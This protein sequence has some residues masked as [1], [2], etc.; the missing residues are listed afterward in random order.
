M[1]KVSKVN[2]AITG[3]ARGLAA[4]TDQASMHLRKLERSAEQSRKRL[5]AM[6]GTSMQT[7]EGLAKLG[8]QSR[9]LGAVG[10]LLGIGALGPAG[11]GLAA[12]GVA[13]TAA[14]QAVGVVGDLPSVRQKAADVLRQSREQGVSAASLGMSR[15]IAEAIGTRP[16]GVGETLS[17]R[18]AFAQGLAAGGGNTVAEALIN[19]LPAVVATQLGA[20]LGGATEEQAAALAFSQLEAGDGPTFPGTG[21]GPGTMQFLVELS[22]WWSK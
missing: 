2:I 5:Q 3:D 13:A 12:A 22:N 9:A 11:F 8:L 7:A 20:R 6:R 14:T 19:K 10:G 21:M 16:V 4:A 1:A 17:V 18:E 15:A